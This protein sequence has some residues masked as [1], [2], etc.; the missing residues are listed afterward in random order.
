[1][2]RNILVVNKSGITLFEQE[3]VDGIDSG[4]TR[5]LGGLVT[6]M[7][8]KAKLNTGMPVS[9]LEMDHIAMALAVSAN[10]GVTTVVVH[11]ADD[12]EIFGK[13]ICETVLRAFIDA[14]AAT[15]RTAQDS[16]A[17]QPDEF[18]TFQY[19]LKG[20]FDACL[21]PVLARMAT[22]RGVLQ[23]FLVAEQQMTPPNASVDRLAIVVN[24]ESLLDDAD[25]IMNFRRDHCSSI[26][27]E[28][29]E[30]LLSV[31]R[32][33]GLALVVKFSRSVAA[34]QRTRVM[35]KYLPL[36]QTVLSQASLAS[37]HFSATER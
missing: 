8:H 26:H 18:R 9:Y 13:L 12:G 29:D 34:S 37:R 21:P 11:D 6:A 2:I 19:S 24:L 32:I 25:S 4:K 33:Q 14:F 16:G 23:A 7:M 35:R 3:F 30:A 31:H 27:L 36:L 20:V 22:E 17:V 10:D 28:S 1:M 15:L 5:I